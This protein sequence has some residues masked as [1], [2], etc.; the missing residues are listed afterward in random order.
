MMNAM[1]D[2]MPDP[3]LA[4]RLID[5]KGTV[6]EGADRVAAAVI[7]ALDVAPQVHVSLV[8]V[9]GVPSSFFNIVLLGVANRF[10]VDAAAN[11]VL[12]DF[13]SDA[14][15]QIYQRSLAAVRS[16]FGS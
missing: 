16:A 9:R 15:R 10:G 1:S 2:L 13:G 14:Q 3:I 6:V 4:D 11:R 8:R 7:A 5:R 12:F